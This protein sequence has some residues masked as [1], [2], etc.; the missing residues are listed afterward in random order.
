MTHT[1]SGRSAW[2]LALDANEI[3]ARMESE[4]GR[5][6]ALEAHIAGAAD[7]VSADHIAELATAWDDFAAA[8]ADFIRWAE[9]DVPA[10]VEALGIVAGEL[11]GKA[12]WYRLE[13]QRAAAR[14]RALAER[15]GKLRAMQ[16]ELVQVFC[17][18]EQASMV[19]LEGGR[20]ARIKVTTSKRVEITNEDALDPALVRTTTSPDK[21]AIGK[22][23]KAGLCVNGA[24]LV[25]TQRQKVVIK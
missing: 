17:D 11:D 24:E 18:V 2:Q 23:L 9:G 20:A 6:G 10:K 3:L 25:Q 5:I 8:E 21:T 13:A 15:A 14:K 19:P 4:T 12:E 1:N 16:L 22:L 7:G